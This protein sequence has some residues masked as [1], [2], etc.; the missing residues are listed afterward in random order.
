MSAKSD[1]VENRASDA[2]PRKCYVIQKAE[3]DIIIRT[4]PNKSKQKKTKIR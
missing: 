1:L 4:Q 3:D 2:N